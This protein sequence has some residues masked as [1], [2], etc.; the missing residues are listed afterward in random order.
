MVADILDAAA[1]GQPSPTH[2]EDF[3]RLFDRT[4]LAI[5]LDPSNSDQPDQHDWVFLALNRSMGR[6]ATAF[7]AALFARELKVG[8]GIPADLRLRL[9]ALLAPNQA[10]H[11]LARIIAASRLSYLYAV[12][13]EWAQASL[14]PSFDW[15]DEEEARPSV[16]G[17]WASSMDN[18]YTRT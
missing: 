2:D 18:L 3:W 6:L 13:P 17:L 15:A 9:D 1:A 12:D 7:F 4:L 5:E 11:R 10:A 16:D 14:I 8:A